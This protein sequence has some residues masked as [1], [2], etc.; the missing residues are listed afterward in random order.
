M[1]PNALLLRMWNYAVDPR[2]DLQK[3]R[4]LHG[5]TSIDFMVLI[6]ERFFINFLRFLRHLMGSKKWYLV[7]FSFLTADCAF[8]ANVWKAC[9]SPQEDIQTDMDAM[10]EL[11]FS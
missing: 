1:V 3:R 2:K 10:M 11:M 4:V 7:P 5:L 8:G 6:S 9:S